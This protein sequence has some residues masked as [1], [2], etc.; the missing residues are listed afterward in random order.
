MN[1][2]LTPFLTTAQWCFFKIKLVPEA[3][4]LIADIG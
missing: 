1:V 2:R 3:V 4:D